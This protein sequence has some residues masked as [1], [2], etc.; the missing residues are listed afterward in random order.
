[1][2]V[3]QWINIELSLLKATFTHLATGERFALIL[4]IESL[5]YLIVI[6]LYNGLLSRAFI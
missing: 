4:H 6:L 3:V 2:L 5:N 1:M